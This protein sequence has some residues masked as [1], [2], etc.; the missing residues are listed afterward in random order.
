MAKIR[1]DYGITF[2]DVLL[3]PKRSSVLPDEVSV[4]TRLTQKI[5]LNIP[6][7]SSAMDTVTESDLAIALAREGGIGVIHR[8]MDIEDQAGEVMR[9]KR[10]ES[11]MIVN[12]ITLPPDKTL[13][14]ALDIMATYH[15]SGV[16]ITTTDGKLVG[17]LTNRDLRFERDMTRKIEDVMTKDGLVTVPEGTTLDSAIDILHKNRIEKLMV[18][19]KNGYLKGL[20][21]V[22]DIMKKLQYPNACKDD[23]GRLRVGSAVGTGPDTI[24]RISALKEAGVDC[25]VIDTA[26]GHSDRVFET[27]LKVKKA[28]SDMDI[29]VGNVCTADATGELIDSGADAVK[30]GIGPSAICTTRVIAGIGIPQISAILECA[31]E[32]DKHSIPIV[33]DGGIKFS[34]DVTKAIAAGACSVMI[35]SLFAGTDESPGEEILYEG[36][37]FKVYY[38]MGSIAAMKVGKSKDRYFQEKRLETAKLV[39]EGIEGRVPFKGPLSDVVYQLVGGLRAGM[40]YVGAKDIENLRTKSEFIRVSHASLIESHPHD[41]IITR[42]APNYGVR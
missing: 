4:S 9:V 6:L 12:P 8:N 5:S 29:I 19:D 11:G 2:D 25:V 34:G 1:D 41:V 16:P 24:D 17:I 36:R 42:E 22:K 40:G 27:L 31:E 28:Y 33:A 37:R 35:G 23:M 26:H 20:I 38:G 39:P 18:V 30:V 10:S 7:L 21:T 14:D 15:I 3:V 13:S 32:A